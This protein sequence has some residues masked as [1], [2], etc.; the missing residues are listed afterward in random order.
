MDRRSR[1][2]SSWESGSFWVPEAPV[3]FWVAMT[4]GVRY[5]VRHAVHRDLPL[6]HGLQQGGLGAAGGPVE[7]VGQEEVAE[8]RA[9][10]VLHFACGLVE[11]GKAGDVGGHDVG[12]E[13]HPV[14]LQVQRP[15]EGQGQG[16]LSHAGDILQQNVALGQNGG[17]DLEEDGVLAHDD[18]FDFRHHVGGEISAVHRRNSFMYGY[19]QESNTRYY[20]AVPGGCQSAGGEK[21]EAVSSEPFHRSETASR[22]IGTSRTVSRVL[23]LTAIYLGGLL[24]DRSSHLLENSRA[25]L[26]FSHGVAPDR[27][28]STGQSPAGG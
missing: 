8:H 5:P 27:V 10:L 20:T 12:G 19:L 14:K 6:L 21:R 15:R 24:P 3:G 9:G 1:K 7:L 2:R 18:L 13:L 16:G 26:M 28:Y 17:Q 22:L 4:E 25:G 11:D 23:Y